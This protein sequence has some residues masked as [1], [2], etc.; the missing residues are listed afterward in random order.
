MIPFRMKLISST[1][2]VS[3]FR[4]V[5]AA[6]IFFLFPACVDDKIISEPDYPQEQP[7]EEATALSFTFRLD[8]DMTTR[9]GS[10]HK[11]KTWDVS[12][13]DA[14]SYAEEF[15]NYIDTQDKFR[16]FFFTEEGDFLFGA[17]DRTIST[18]GEHSGSASTYTVR[19]PMNVLVDRSGFEYPVEKIK[20]YLRN[21]K[22]KVAVL[23]NWPNAGGKINPGDYD[24]G[25]NSQDFGDNPSSTLKGHPM[26]GYRNSVLYDPTGDDRSLASQIGEKNVKNINDL[27]HLFD[28]VNIYASTETTS[29]RPYSNRECYSPF[30]A[31]NDDGVLAMGEP[32]DW[33][34]MRD[35]NEGWHADYDMKYVFSF[36]SK[37]TANQWIRANWNPDKDLNN[38]KK[39]YR[40]YQHLWYLW[41]FDASYK[42]GL[43]KTGNGSNQRY[44]SAY[45]NNFGWN[46]G[47]TQGVT[48]TWGEQWYKRNG[49]TLYGKMDA[50]SSSATPLQSFHI[51]S[52]KEGQNDSFFRFN[53]FTNGEKCYRVTNP[54]GESGYSS[55][56]YG[57]RLPS[58]GKSLA[59]NTSPGT[60]VFEARTAGTLRVKWGNGNSNSPSK[61]CIQKGTEWQREYTIASGNRYKIFDLGGTSSPNET[62]YDISM[63]GESVPIFIYCSEG[64][65]V[66][67]A[68][69]YIRGKYLFETDREG[70]VPTE[71]QGIPMY[72][73]QNF[74]PVSDWKDGSTC[75]LTTTS[76][77]KLLRSLAKVEVYIPT[78]FDQPRHMYMRYMNRSARCEPM[79][80]EDPIAWDEQST[81]EG[82]VG[83]PRSCEFFSLMKYGPTYN[84]TG[85]D[86][87]GYRN[88][89]SW[90]Y[91]S[92]ASASWLHESDYSID[93]D[94]KW[95][96]PDNSVKGF[97]FNGLLTPKTAPEGSPYPK[98]FNPYI[99]RSDFC[100]FIYM[101]KVEDKKYY[102]YVLYVPEKYIDD[103]HYPG[104]FNSTPR[105][106]HIE[107][108]FDPATTLDGKESSL[109]HSEF[110]LD[111]DKCFRIYF[112]NYGYDSSMG[113]HNPEI[114]NKSASSYNSYEKNKENLKYHWPI[115]RNHKYQ[116]YV[117]GD[118]PDRITV[119]VR[120][121]DWK[122]EKM[123]T[124]W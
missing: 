89:L 112:T 77:F 60:F 81:S 35:V 123:V 24:D 52:S 32:T 115:I 84:T 75:N 88:W 58:R 109:T 70:V 13:D 85:N 31:N 16:V 59:E 108:R 96:L 99:N 7:T 63:E 68:I 80:V 69:E 124:E 33:V 119:S 38:D 28:E 41:N 57:I 64:D 97:G 94:G 107:Y 79:N 36:D 113:E 76:E 72:G 55:D 11:G 5:M 17:I 18:G 40:H 9:A 23:A 102:K 12:F 101:G 87:S 6:A 86:L 43:Y 61:L 44:A 2:C 93:E 98:I 105:V 100:H 91:G 19:I 83:H 95:S 92:W 103:P 26:W 110:N 106:P 51:V 37:E 34:K 25:D 30:M 117:G 116:F 39:I 10:D 47:F 42:Y 8:V 29:S 82:S 20:S 50:A 78:T 22:F 74:D 120:I 121:K 49:S 54:T 104:V 67:Y 73:V 122:H 62:F 15:E 65:A 45:Q 111:D 1:Y 3:F 48:N 66:I 14:N 71:K 46:N 4:M 90:F 114:A 27:H 53:A 21:N 118:A 56:Y